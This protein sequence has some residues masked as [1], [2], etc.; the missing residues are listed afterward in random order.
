MWHDERLLISGELRPAE[1]NRTFETVNP[2]TEEVMGTA[3]DAT[4][5][6]TRE[7]IQ[8][9]RRAFDRTD[10]ATDPAFRARCL[11]QLQAGFQAE[12]ENLRPLIVAETGVP[13]VL[14]T[15][16]PALDTPVEMIGWYADLLDRYEFAPVPTDHIRIFAS[17]DWPSFGLLIIARPIASGVVPRP[18]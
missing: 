14:T 3:A 18:K 16:G 9:S 12:A 5:A 15:G 1:G 2:S 17:F 10:W 4:L 6:D 8:D 11:R 13:V 7:A